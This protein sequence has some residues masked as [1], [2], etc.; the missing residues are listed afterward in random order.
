MRELVQGLNELC[1]TVPFQT[2]WY[3][4]DLVGKMAR[5]CYDALGRH[6]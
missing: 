4:K 6:A 5:L 2:S 3:L 1:D